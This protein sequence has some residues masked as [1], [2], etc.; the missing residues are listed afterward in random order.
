MNLYSA[1]TM[2]IG[3]RW[4]GTPGELYLE[5]VSLLPCIGF[6]TVHHPR[7]GVTRTPRRTTG[8]RTTSHR[9]RHARRRAATQSTLD[10]LQRETGDRPF[11]QTRSLQDWITDHRALLETAEI[12]R[13]LHPIEN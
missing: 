7:C 3:R 4:C 1:A 13:S 8:A 10:N 5:C 9:S 11:P 2:A 6:P 12:V